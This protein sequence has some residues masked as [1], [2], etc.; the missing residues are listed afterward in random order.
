M[1]TEAGD[2]YWYTSVERSDWTLGNLPEGFE[3]LLVLGTSWKCLEILALKRS[4]LGGVIRDGGFVTYPSTELKLFVDQYRDD[5]HA[6]L[7]LKSKLSK[8]V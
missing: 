2:K 5:F 4:S 6:E 1:P 3:E 7:K 8:G